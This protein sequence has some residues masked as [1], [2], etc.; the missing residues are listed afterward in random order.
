V[1]RTLGLR[2]RQLTAVAL[3]QI[4]TLTVLAMLAGLP[5]GAAAGR[6][7]WAAFAHVLGIAPGTGVPV[8]TGLLLVPAVLLAAN[9]VACWPARRNFRLRPAE[10]LRVE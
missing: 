2:R 6:W 5:A 8:L 9:L 7:A 1:L 3:W 10:L 4:T